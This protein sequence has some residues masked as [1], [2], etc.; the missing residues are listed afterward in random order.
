MNKETLLELLEPH[1]QHLTTVKKW[2]VYAKEHKLP[3]SVN[4]I[5]HFKS[6]SNVKE[7][8]RLPQLKKTYT[9]EQLE[10][11]AFSHKEH[12]LR[13]SIWDEYSKE[14]GLPASATFI[15]AFGSWQK[16]KEHIGLVNEKRKNDLYSKEDIQMVLKE[17]AEHYL[18]RTQ[19]DEYAKEQRLPTYKTIKKHFEYD[20]ILDIVGKEKPSPHSKVNLIKIALEHQDYF[21]HSSMAKWDV[22]AA[23]NKLPS[24]F[25]FYKVFGSWQKAKYE[26]TIRK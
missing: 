18:N 12:F 5:Y 19:W 6:W 22:Y 24:S 10:T 13:K 20:E 7:A 25:I 26:V 3:P 1:K 15:K 8:M 17:H 16:I 23:Q 9:F 21:L 11:I 4:L 14:H 2:D